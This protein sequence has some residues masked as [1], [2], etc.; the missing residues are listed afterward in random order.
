MSYITLQ[1][2]QWLHISVEYGLSYGY[3]QEW[4]SDDWQRLAGCGPTTA[5]QLLAYASF[6]DG[7]ANPAEVSDVKGALQWM[8]KIWSYVKPHH[9]GLYKTSWFEAGVAKYIE[10][11]HLPYEVKSLHIYPFKI[12]RP[13]LEEVGS[14]IQAGLSQDGPVAFLNRHRGNEPELSTWHWVPLVG[15]RQDG[16]IYRGTVYD[17]EIERQFSLNSWL[18]NTTL[19]GGFVYLKRK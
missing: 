16:K 11:H 8:E 18:K 13:S 9:G 4:Y 19:G 12:N 17:E 6:R 7:F 2:P 5:S 14:F 10:E 15:L 1:M 3:N